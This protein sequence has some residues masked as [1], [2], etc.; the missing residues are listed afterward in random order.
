VWKIQEQTQP[1]YLNL[2]CLLPFYFNH[3]DPNPVELLSSASPVL[4][5]H[6]GL[7]EWLSRSSFLHSLGKAENIQTPQPASTLAREYMGGL[8]LEL[9]KGNRS[10]GSECSDTHWRQNGRNF[11]TLK[12]QKRLP[13]RA[14]TETRLA[15]PIYF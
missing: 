7:H 3:Y 6:R 2:T 1:F 4:E 15:L 10:E 13:S 14:V 9:S 12:M 11:I 8:S 5:I